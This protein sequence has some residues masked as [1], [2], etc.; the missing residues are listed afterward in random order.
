M[1]D[2]VSW[3]DRGL[4]KAAGNPFLPSLSL[5]LSDGKPSSIA[6]CDCPI[7]AS[8]PAIS[9]EKDVTAAVAGEGEGTS[10]REE[11]DVAREG[12]SFSDTL[13]GSLT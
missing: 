11:E 10:L 13:A 6:G 8:I 2:T 7:L 1:A 3:S 4:P 12:V 5:K 9:S